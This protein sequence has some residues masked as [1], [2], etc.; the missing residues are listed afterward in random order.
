MQGPPFPLFAITFFFIALG[1]AFQDSQANTFVSTVQ[2][3]HR[4]LGVIHASYAAGCLVGPLIATSIAR[5]TPGKWNLFYWAPFVMGLLNIGL[6]GWAFRS[7][8]NFKVTKRKS[9]EQEELGIDMAVGGVERQ[10][11]TSREMRYKG[12]LEMKDTLKEKNVW[13]LSLFFFFY[14]GT[15]ITAGGAFSTS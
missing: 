5:S 1:Q 15:A 2:V 7:D 13:K 11:E 9:L 6:V 3:A 10:A 8:M 14:L 12:L 4:W